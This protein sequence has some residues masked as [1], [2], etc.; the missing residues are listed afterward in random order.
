MHAFFC[1][2]TPNSPHDFVFCQTLNIGPSQ[3]KKKTMHCQCVFCWKQQPHAQIMTEL[4]S[5]HFLMGKSLLARSSTHTCQT[6]VVRDRSYTDDFHL[7]SL[8]HRLMIIP[9]AMLCIFT[10]VFTSVHIHMDVGFTMYRPVQSPL[11]LH[12]SRPV[13]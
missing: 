11:I 8:V 10:G 13:K 6:G 9:G 1:R 7:H 5:L 12:M 3:I 4:M 2:Y